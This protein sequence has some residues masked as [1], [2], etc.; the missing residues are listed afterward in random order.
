MKKLNLIITTIIASCA[1]FS[2]SSNDNEDNL[3]KI[4]DVRKERLLL[5]KQSSSI[6]TRTILQDLGEDGVYAS[7]EMGDKAS[8]FNKNFPAAGYMTVT[9]S[10]STKNTNFSGT[11]N[12]QE[13][14]VIRMFYPEVNN[15]NSVTDE[16]NSGTLTLDISKQKGTLE[17]IQLNYDFCYGEAT[18]S[19]VTNDN[20]VADMGTS[21]NL[22]AICKFTFKSNN[23]YLKNINKVIITGVHEKGVFTLSAA[24]P[25]LTR[26][27]F[28]DFYNSAKKRNAKSKAPEFSEVE[29]SQG[30]ITIDAGN[31][32]NSV[33]VALYP[34]STTPS[35]ELITN[36]G[37][38]EGTLAS[39]NLKAGK[40]Y[41]VVVNL[42]KTGDAANEDYVEVCG[43]KWAKGKLQYDPVNGGDE[44]FEENWRIAPA[45]WHFVGY[46]VD[47]LTLNYINNENAKDLFIFAR[48]KSEAYTG[49]T[50][51]AKDDGLDISEKL[52]YNE[53]YEK[54]RT[55]HDKANLGD[56]AYW[57]SNG[58]YRLPIPSEF[59]YLVENAS[60]EFG[61]IIKGNSTVSG[62]LFTTPQGE[63]TV[64]ESPKELTDDDLNRGLFLPNSGCIRYRSGTSKY[65]FNRYMTYYLTSY[66]RTFFGYHEYN[67]RTKFEISFSTNDYEGRMGGRYPI[68]P[69]LCE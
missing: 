43:I 65:E 52:F 27:Q 49:Y 13:G 60:Y 40:F 9:A 28:A 69:V 17:D 42:T 57:A 37:K 7:W 24:H 58:K 63:R 18:V 20:A 10:S 55:D 30:I 16:N 5:I 3:N 32:D 41:N 22:M 36:E 23:E 51:P 19:E 64:S 21:D 33:Y 29:Q 31:V 15:V 56:L 61:Y 4:D 1:F 46:D 44:G 25:E 11:V 62:V 14:D 45:Q 50:L 8:I 6:N 26:C 47:D 35:F 48:L 38:Y 53:V 68:R 39:S 2:C 34:G 66:D 67:N 12:C 54:Y 59:K